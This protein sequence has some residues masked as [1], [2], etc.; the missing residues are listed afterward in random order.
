MSTR[1]L[2]I[3]DMD[4]RVSYVSWADEYRFKKNNSLCQKGERISGSR[5]KES[6]DLNPITCDTAVK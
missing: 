6:E 1:Q 3:L 2:I 4:Y 5:E